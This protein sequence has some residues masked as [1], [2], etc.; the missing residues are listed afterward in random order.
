LNIYSA[1]F[2]EL[3]NLII[4]DIE[5]LSNAFMKVLEPY[6]KGF[7]ALN[8]AIDEV[9]DKLFSDVAVPETRRTKQ[10]QKR[11]RETKKYTRG[12]RVYRSCVDLFL[13]LSK[14]RCV[15][16]RMGGW[17]WNLSCVS[18]CRGMVRLQGAI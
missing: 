17:V 12:L 10:R 6:R 14:P 11:L 7:E 13:H 5:F 18:S 16:Q 4:R 9:Y 1:L 8:D 15:G 2:E 3:L